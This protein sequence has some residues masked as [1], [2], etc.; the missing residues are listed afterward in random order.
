[1]ELAGP[2]FGEAAILQLG[3]AF[4]KVTAH[5]LQRPALVS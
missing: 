3:H 4:Q 1:M 2:A 5:H